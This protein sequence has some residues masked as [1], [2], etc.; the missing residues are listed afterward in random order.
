MELIFSENKS[1]YNQLDIA[2]KKG[3]AIVVFRNE[4]PDEKSKLWARLKRC[5]NWSMVEAELEK[6]KDKKDSVVERVMSPSMAG[7]L[8]GGEIILIAWIATLLAGLLF[9]G[10]Y[11]ECNIKFRANKNGEIDIEIDNLGM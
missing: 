3:G 8:A 4:K 1:F 2:I 9:Y 6:V 5:K 7:A 10:I 11:K